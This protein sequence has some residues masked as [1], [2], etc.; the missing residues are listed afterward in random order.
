MIIVIL[1]QQTLAS[2][3]DSP[4]HISKVLACISPKY[5]K[6]IGKGVQTNQGKTD[7]INN[8]VRAPIHC[9]LLTCYTQWYIPRLI[10]DVHVPVSVV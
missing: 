8:A 1:L 9:R 6:T 3:T 4:Q 7:Y 10:V 2:E 5:W